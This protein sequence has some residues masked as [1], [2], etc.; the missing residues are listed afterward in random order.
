[1]R[2]AV[3]PAEA[4]TAF[5]RL[6]RERVDKVVAL[7]AK[8]ASAK[9]AGPVGAVIRDAMMRFGFK[10]FV[11]PESAAWLLRHHSSWDE[12]VAAAR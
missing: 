12:E 8:T 3:G 4:F 9:A 1:V 2:D 7:G 6:R 11:K 10:F 5:E